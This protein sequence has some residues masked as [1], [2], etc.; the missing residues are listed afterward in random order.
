MGES[1]DKL[2]VVSLF[3]GA[4][5][6]DIAACSSGLVGRLLSTDSNPVFL[7][8]VVNNMP[9]HFPGIEHHHLVADALSLT[10]DMVR[11]ALGE[12]DIDLVMGGPPC[13]D[14]TPAGR[15]R[16]LKGD[17]APLVFEFVRLVVETKPDAFIFENVPNLKMMCRTVL[18]DLM[19]RLAE[20]GYCI[21]H[22][23]L[24]AASFG[25]PSVRRRLF[26]VGFRSRSA[27]SL[28]HFPFPT[29]SEEARQLPLPGLGGGL[30]P[31]VTVG[32]VL[33]DLPDVTDP[34]AAFFPN[35]EGRK[36]RPQTVEHLKTVPQ[37]VAVDKSYRYR[38]PWGGLCRSLTA[39]L[40]DSA[41]A[42]IHP[43]HH[44]EMSVR[45]YARI[46]GFPDSWVFAGRLDSGLK[47]IA[48][49]VPV[50]LGCAVVGSVLNA[51]TRGGK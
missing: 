19:T 21:A 31:V 1:K 41:K 26:V 15:K 2:T 20:A 29:H 27:L 34:R 46:H 16:G 6:L 38:A 9:R 37:G 40:D 49:A 35:H 25:V 32:D 44:R 28:F 7:Q 17:K 10:G 14:F 4:G 3:A 43:L 36:H 42:Y 50:P 30:S 13:D 8:T 22:D 45:E 33:H 51:M 24:S 23:I 5:G 11:Q 39:G 18:D 12:S 47:Q 48:N